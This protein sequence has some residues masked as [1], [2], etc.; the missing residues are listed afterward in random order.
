M[1]AHRKLGMAVSMATHLFSFIATNSQK[2]AGF[3]PGLIKQI[4]LF[5][6]INLTEFC[7]SGF[8]FGRRFVVS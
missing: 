8:Q 3:F 6:W 7:R 1:A 5:D 4:R 2:V